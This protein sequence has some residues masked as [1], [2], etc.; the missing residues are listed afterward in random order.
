MTDSA[1]AGS[2]SGA[3]LFARYAFPPNELGY[4]GPEGSE[5]LLEGGAR[6]NLD[7][8]VGRRAR[9]FD[10]AWPYLRLIAAAAGIDDPL[11]RRVVHAYWLGSDLLDSVAADSL[12]GV[13]AEQ[14]GSQPGVAERL[15]FDGGIA[16]AGPHH[17]FHV[18]VVYPWVGMLDKDSDV[19]RSV[20][21]SCRV[22]WGRVVSVQDGGARVA[23]RTLRLVDGLLS[24]GDEEE[25]D[26]RWSSGAHAFV[27]DL[28]PGEQVAVH[29]DWICDRLD[30]AEVEALR[31]RTETQLDA[32]NRW[33]A[34]AGAGVPHAP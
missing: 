27:T 32:A 2:R 20:L 11:D 33:L 28:R 6:G 4:C 8:E 12:T 17:G 10:G 15:A 7:D 18:L 25:L 31:G 19:P 5:V 26:A 9:Q 24:L 30:T 16:D 34:A 29:W 23:V 1:L 3:A 14:F 13:V 21:D 22:R